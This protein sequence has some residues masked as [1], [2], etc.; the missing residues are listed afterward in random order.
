MNH[1]H[2]AANEG[3]HSSD[4][5]TLREQERLDIGAPRS[6]RGRRGGEIDCCS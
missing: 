5:E 3:E 1:E 4:H 6:E 2:E